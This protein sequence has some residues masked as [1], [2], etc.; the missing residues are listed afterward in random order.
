MTSG[1][2]SKAVLLHFSGPDKPGIT[3]SLTGVLAG[4]EANVLDIGQAVVHENLVLGI[5]LEMPAGSDSAALRSA[6]QVR[7]HELGLQRQ[8]FVNSPR[9]RCAIGCTGCIITISSLPCWGARSLR[10]I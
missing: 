8:V 1:T 2:R 9:K 4:F 10:S 3:A 7:A 5:L 6:M